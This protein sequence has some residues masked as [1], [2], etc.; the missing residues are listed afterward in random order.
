MF[1]LAQILQYFQFM[2]GVTTPV[3]DEDL[4]HCNNII[5]ILN[6]RLVNKEDDSS[7]YLLLCCQMCD[8]RDGLQLC[9]HAQTHPYGQHCPNR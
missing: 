9:V 1:L 7:D 2:K 3:A 6:L 4:F 8:G 5:K